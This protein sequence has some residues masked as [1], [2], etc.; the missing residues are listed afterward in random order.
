MNDTIDTDKQESG[1]LKGSFGDRGINVTS[2]G[3]GHPH[4][5]TIIKEASDILWESKIGRTLLSVHT[6]HKVPIQIIKGTGASGFNP[7]SNI[8][9]LQIPNK[10][11]KATPDMVIH[12][13]KA[14]READQEIMGFTA[15]DPS[16]DLMEYATVM[17]S[18][19]LDAIIHVCKVVK[20]LTNS[21]YYSVL[22]DSLKKLG[23]IK[24]YQAYEKDA[25]KEELFRAYAN[26]E[27]RG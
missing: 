1:G 20:E 2:M 27:E 13:I 19:T 16:K 8:I 26:I 18:K 22:L 5:E 24:V 12:L 15:P 14:L 25:S 6:H 3:Y 21:S 4:A 17:H 7:Q 9:F 10:E 23:H 11:T